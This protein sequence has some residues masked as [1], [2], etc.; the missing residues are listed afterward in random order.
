M[1]TKTLDDNL[2]GKKEVEY[3]NYV[4]DLL[5]CEELVMTVCSARSKGD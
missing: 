3:I 4:C 1:E 5:R 2:K